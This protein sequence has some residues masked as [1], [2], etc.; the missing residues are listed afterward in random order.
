[1]IGPGMRRVL[2]LM[3]L[4]VPA[5]LAARDFGFDPPR[6]ADDGAAAAVMRDLAQRLVPVYQEADTDIYLA[7]LAAMQIVSGAF[8]AADDTSQNLRNRHQDAPVDTALD[9]AIIDIIYANAR[10]L[11]ARERIAFAQAYARAFQDV[12]PQL[13][14]AH[15]ASV[16]AK[17]GAPLAAYRVPV[18]QAFDRWRAKGSIPEADAVALVRSYLAYESHRSYAPL[19][20]KLAAAEDGRRYLVEADVLIPSRFGAAIHASIVRPASARWPVPT[21]LRFTLDPS[22]DDAKRSA[23]HGYVGITAYVRGRRPDGRGAVLPFRH[24]GDDAKA[25]IDWIAQQDWSDGRVA[26]L[27]DGYSGYAAWAAASKKPAALKGIATIAPIAP[28]IDFPIAGQIFHNAMARWA[29]EHTLAK[30]LAAE[31]SA[32]D[33]KADARWRALDEVWYRSGRAYQGI[34]RALL[35]KRSTLLRTWLTHPSHDRYWQKLLPTAKQFAQIDVPV[36][37]IAGY[38]GAEAGA[39]YYHQEHL[40]ARPQADNTLLIGPYDPGSIK[41]GTGSGLRGMAIDPVA[42]VDLNA[43]RFEWLAHLLKGAKKPAL[44]QGRVNYEVMGAN[45]WRQMPTL[46]A[47]DRPRLRLYLDPQERG[48]QQRDGQ[49]REAQQRLSLKPTAADGSIELAVDLSQRKVAPPLPSRA[50]RLGELQLLDGLRFVSDALPKEIELS[51]SLLGSFEITP[52]RQDFDLNIALYE[53]TASGTYQLL[54][55]PY[56]L[57]ASY[58]GDRTRRRLLAAGERQVLTVNTERMTAA[59]LAAGSRIVLVVG[60]NNRADRQVNSGSGKAVNSETIADAAAPLRVRWHAGSYVEL[61]S[62]KP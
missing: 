38:F 55:E 41:L 33:P 24:D 23:T 26:M 36:F 40:R 25:V 20:P 51:G 30:P 8:A 17:L 48:G 42:Q 43:L 12:M 29:Q 58:A 62:E 19:I 27:G 39:L 22:E 9:R 54:F 1:M 46:A 13:D 31:P 7:N 6:S 35:G 60:I 50:L 49:Q 4:A 3:L 37:G 28:G 52:S 47:P 5:W 34:D 61:L 57:R 14:D 44:L 53:L 45:Q 59:K 16:A 15:A 56:D 32:G 2:A 21:L 18:Q 10:A 11:E